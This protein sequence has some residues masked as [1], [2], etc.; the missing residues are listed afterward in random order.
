MTSRA[1]ESPLFSRWKDSVSGIESSILS[2]RVAPQQQT[3]YFCNP[4]LSADGR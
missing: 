4:S 2:T 3:F 1:L